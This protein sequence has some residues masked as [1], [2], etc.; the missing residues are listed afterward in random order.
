MAVGHSAALEVATALDATAALEAA[1]SEECKQLPYLV[2]CQ[3][4]VHQ[5]KWKLDNSA[6]GECHQ[7]PQ[8][9]QRHY[10]HT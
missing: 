4:L 3:Q 10:G 6:T 9:A 8:V 5:A 2:R 1:H 7:L